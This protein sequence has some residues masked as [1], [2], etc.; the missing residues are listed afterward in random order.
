M[1]FSEEKGVELMGMDLQL[2]QYFDES[3]RDEG[4]GLSGDAS[5][6]SCTGGIG[7]AA[8]RSAGAFIVRGGPLSA[9]T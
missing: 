8:V 3:Y 9:R 7:P 2:D 1:V 4:D 6:G 5:N